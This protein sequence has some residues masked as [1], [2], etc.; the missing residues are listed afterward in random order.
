MKK[1]GGGNREQG[2]VTWESLLGLGDGEVEWLPG[3]WVWDGTR[4]GGLRGW[5]VFVLEHFY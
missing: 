3:E 1:K 5:L 2:P 4:V